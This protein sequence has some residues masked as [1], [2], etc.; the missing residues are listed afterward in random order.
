MR[1]AIVGYGR[2]GKLLE[3]TALN[4]GHEITAIIDLKNREDIYKLPK[5]TE[6]V[7][8]FAHVPGILERI[9]AVLK[10]QLPMVIGTTGWYEERGG[11][12]KNLVKTYD[13]AVVYGAN[14]SIGM[15]LLFLLNKTLATWMNHFPEYD[16]GIYEV[17]H[18]Y[19][20]DAPSGSAMRLATD[21]LTYLQ[22][23]QRLLFPD[24]L[25]HQAP[26]AEG[27]TIAYQRIGEEKGY[28]E[29]C[30]Y[31]AVDQITI[32][33][34]ALSREGFVQGALLAAQ[35]IQH[36]KGFWDFF[37]IFEEQIKQPTTNA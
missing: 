19:K 25:R 20:Q 22:R 9:E 8:E 13:G 27:L 30:Y 7:I 37:T 6:V 32:R 3:K 34:K 2:M 24:A 26:A 18:R 21:I 1:I 12:V 28:H 23:K 4:Q 10:Q 5:T 35:W 17:H 29:V 11:M 15:N 36:K 31:S 16:C 33:H 14:F